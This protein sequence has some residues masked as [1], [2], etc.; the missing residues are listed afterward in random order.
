MRILIKIILIFL[1]SISAFAGAIE[2]DQATVKNNWYM[3]SGIKNPVYEWVDSSHFL[4]YHHKSDSRHY[5]DGFGDS[6]HHT[7]FW[8]TAMLLNKSNEYL[9]QLY[10]RPGIEIRLI[11]VDGKAKFQRHPRNSPDD[12]WNRD[13]LTSM[14]YP[15]AECGMAE[16]AK[17]AL[18]AHQGLLWPQQWMNFERSLNIKHNYIV[19]LI[20]DSF[21]CIDAIVDWFSGDHSSNI[22]NVYRLTIAS[23]RY[24][25]FLT[26]VA[27]WI[28]K[29]NRE[30]KD[31]MEEYFSRAFSKEDTPPPIHKDWEQII[32]KY[33]E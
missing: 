31:V 28:L 26:K 1:I 11:I 18:N 21:E 30:P 23:I 20:A 16:E 8:L 13:Q 6:P 27:V 15:M 2:K 4:H 29:L 7:G 32:D 17:E 9:C 14:V 25:T 12:Y 3:N 22:K 33:L 10:L 24:P 19:R 5:T